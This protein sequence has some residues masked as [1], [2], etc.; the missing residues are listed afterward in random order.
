MPRSTSRYRTR[1]RSSP[2]SRQGEGQGERHGA[3][4][5]R[6]RRHARGLHEAAATRRPVGRM[7]DDG[8]RAN[9]RRRRELSSRTKSSLRHMLRGVVVTHR[10]W[11]ALKRASPSHAARLGGVLPGLRRAALPGRLD[12]GLPARSRAR[13]REAHP[14]RQ[15]QE[16]ADLRPAVLGGLFRCH[17]PAATAA[18]IGQTADGLPI[19]VQ[20]VGPQYGDYPPSRSPSCWRRNTAASC[21]HPPIQ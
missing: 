18:P 17:Q 10:D 5:I 11:L 12:G 6:H 16:G 3:A 7:P 4:G 8:V 14:D 9:A 2:I 20:I 15:Q 13:P 1:S 21:R 19:G